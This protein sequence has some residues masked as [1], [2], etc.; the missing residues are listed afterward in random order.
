[1]DISRRRFFETASASAL[2]AQAALGAEIDKKTGMPTRIL[3]RTGAR[4]SVIAFG[5]GSRLLGYKDKNKAIAIL[6]RA[7]DQGVSYLDTAY[8][9]GNGQSEEWLGE[10]VKARKKD[11]WLATKINKRNGDEAMKII[12]GSLKRLQTDRIDL[13]HIHSLT[14]EKDL[15]AIE[16]NDGILKVLYKLRDQKVARAIGVTSHT[17]PRVLATALERHDFDCTQMALNAARVGQAKN[18]PIDPAT[19]SFE[20]LAVP[21]AVKKKM[22]ITGMKIFA[23]EAL[24]GKAPVEKL[25]R[26]TLSLPV[27]AAVLGM[28]KPEH[29]EENIAIGKAFKPLSKSEMRFLA[30]RLTEHKVAI[31]TFFQNHVDA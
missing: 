8:N 26:Y 20:A 9:Y 4:V 15:A 21:V 1:M 3:G 30:A 7:L 2:A 13:I 10:L 6:N 16:A 22:G 28:P 25:I 12:E 19:T 31:D 11:F 18:V 5:C 14:D 23:Q 24:V 29:V 27:A 17:D